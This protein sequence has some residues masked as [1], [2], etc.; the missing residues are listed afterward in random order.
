MPF[1]Y[2]ASVAIFRERKNILFKIQCNPRL[3]FDVC[4]HPDV[5][6]ISALPIRFQK[7]RRLLEVS[8]P[9]AVKRHIGNAALIRIVDTPLRKG[10]IFPAD[11]HL[12]TAGGS[13]TGEC[14]RLAEFRSS[15]D[16]VVIHN[17]RCRQSCSSCCPDSR[18]RG[19][20]GKGKRRMDMVVGILRKDGW[21]LLF[22]S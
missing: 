4:Q 3:L 12:H 11:S 18:C 2:A 13:H 16:T 19:I 22:F 17:S 15:A 14:S 9:D 6:D 7:V 21:F 20:R 10:S 8:L 1:C 5:S